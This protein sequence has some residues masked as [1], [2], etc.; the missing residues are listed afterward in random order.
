MYGLQLGD[1]PQKKVTRDSGLGMWW[2]VR[3][4][5]VW[6]LGIRVNVI[7]LCDVSR[8][9]GPFVV[10]LF[11]VVRGFMSKIYLLD[12]TLRDGGYVNN[13]EFGYEAIAQIKTGLEDSGI[14]II[15][16]GFF[17]NEP[18][19]HDRSV[20]GGAEDISQVMKQRKANVSSTIM[21]IKGEI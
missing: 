6:G 15:E 4:G 2:R 10:A 17:R 9:S 8:L 3:L 18:W 21:I 1:F 11:F 16:I 20:F 13:W 5:S 7:S 19:N 12:C 14:D